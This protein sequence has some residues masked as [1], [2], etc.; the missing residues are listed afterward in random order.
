MKRTF[1]V[2]AIRKVSIICD[3]ASQ[4]YIGRAMQLAIGVYLRRS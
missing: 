2:L 3:P 4:R 1:R